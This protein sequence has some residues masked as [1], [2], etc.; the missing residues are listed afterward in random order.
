MKRHHVI[1][2]LCG[3]FLL[4]VVAESSTV[5]ESVKSAASNFISTAK[6]AISGISEGIVD[7]RKEGESTD[8]AHIASNQQELAELLSFTVISAEELGQGKYQLTLAVRNDNPFLVRVTNLSQH[9][10]IVLLDKD[11][12]SYPLPTPAIQGTDI[13]AIEKSLTR[14]RYTFNNVEGEPKTLRIFATELPITKL[15]PVSPAIPVSE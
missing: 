7:G 13:T 9:N 14:V 6:D 10:S 15:V 8:K 1:P 12:F 2:F 5:K 3:F 4:P 11:G